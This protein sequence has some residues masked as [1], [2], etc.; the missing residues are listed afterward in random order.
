MQIWTKVQLGTGAVNFITGMGG[1][2]QAV[3][4]G[5]GGL[6]LDVDELRFRRAELPSG[7]TEIAFKHIAYLGA[8]FDFEVTQHFYALHL[9][10]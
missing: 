4:F 1:F 9:Q 5:Y 10:L 2:L 6:R 8:E 7:V 3:L